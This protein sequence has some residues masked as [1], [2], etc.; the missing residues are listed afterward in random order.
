M[1]EVYRAHDSKLGRDVA[2]KILPAAFAFDPDRLARFGREAQVLASLNHPHI[3]AIYGF[4]EANEVRALV[5]ELVEGPTLADRIADGP[6]GIEESLKIAGEIADALDAAHEKG[7]V[8]RDLKPA[9]IKTTRDGRVKVLDFGLAKMRVDGGTAAPSNTPTITASVSRPGV[10]VGTA[11]YMSPEQAQGKPVDKRTDIWAFGCVLFELLSG[12]RAFA[13]ENAA[14]CLVSVLTREPDWALLPAATPPRIVELLRRC[15]RKDFRQRL[16]DIGDA[17]IEILSGDVV[18]PS[19]RRG[20]GRAVGAAVAVLFAGVAAGALAYRALGRVSIDPPTPRRLT[21]ERGEVRAARFAPDGNTVVYSARWRGEPSFE[22]FM[23]RLDSRESRALGLSGHLDAVSAKS[24]LAFSPLSSGSGNIARVPLAGGAPRE[25]MDHVSWAD[26]AADGT[27]LAV[28]RDLQNGERIEFPVGNVIYETSDRMTNLR[29]SPR[30]EW[31][32]FVQH[33][34]SSDGGSLELVSRTGAT[35]VLSSDWADVV[36]VAWQPDGR[37]IWFTAAKREETKSLRAVTMEGRERVLARLLGQMTLQDIDRSG[38]ALIAQDHFGIEMRAHGP[39]SATEQDLTWL[40]L[41]DVASIS[42]D[43]RRVLFTVF[44]EGDAESGQTYIRQTDGTPAVRLGEGRALALSPDGKW[45]LSELT[46]PSRLV[47]LPTGIGTAKTLEGAGL[48]YLRHASWFPDGRRVA[49]AAQGNNSPP[50]LYVQDT[51]GGAPRPVGPADVRLPLVAPDGRMIA[52]LTRSGPVL[53]SLD[54]PD[55][56]PFPGLDAHDLPL[57]WTADGRGLFFLRKGVPPTV[58]IHR[59]E[60]SSVHQKLVWTLTV[61]DSAGVRNP[62]WVTVTPDG[63]YYA[64]SFERV[65]SDL[66]LLEGLK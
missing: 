44:S 40:G 28:V 37:E 42:A 26:W 1:G 49:F 56:R 53:L 6:L 14:E 17:R 41:S 29:V 23:T 46:S 7:I 30:G 57:A 32:A 51:D 61:A 38:R 11:A 16:R 43:G 10:T 33:P 34:P 55:P 35:R 50:R 9:N 45:A 39:S 59:I 22:L 12:T 25:V 31:L 52:G 13:G 20:R 47:L 36:G 15:L 27:D 64:Y 58:E 66:Y 65:L 62:E 4:E 3:A 5:M 18:A 2:I 8:H 60:L 21:F 48:T 63:K 19:E 54:A 24:E